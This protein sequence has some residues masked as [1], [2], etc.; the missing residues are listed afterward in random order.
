MPIAPRSLL[1]VVVAAVLAALALPAA[2]S[3]VAPSLAKG[4]S[5]RVAVGDDFFSPAALRVD[6]GTKVKWKWRAANLNTHNVVLTGRHPRGV[7]PAKFRSESGATG[8]RFARKLKRSGR[9]VFIC[10]FH[11]ETMRMKIKVNR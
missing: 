3:S 8:I 1:L 11:R 10:E 2:G 5:E 7:K 9:Y 6:R 4:S